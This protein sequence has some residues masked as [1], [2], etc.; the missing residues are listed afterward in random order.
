M[1]VEYARGIDREVEYVVTV[2]VAY[3]C[4]ECH[5]KMIALVVRD[6]EE[7]SL[8]YQEEPIACPRCTPYTEA[9]KALAE[10]LANKL[11]V[12]KQLRDFY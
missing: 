5:E 3:E 2:S 9:F 11:D 10:S 1:T 7:P 6:K 12:F 8:V 4:I